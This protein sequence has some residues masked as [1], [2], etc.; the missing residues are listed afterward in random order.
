M[1]VNGLCH[2]RVTSD[3]FLFLKFCYCWFLAVC[4]QPSMV[5]SRALRKLVQLFKLLNA[6]WF[7]GSSESHKSLTVSTTEYCKT[8]IMSYWH[9]PYILNTANIV[10]WSAPLLHEQGSCRCSIDTSTLKSQDY[11]KL[12]S[13]FFWII[14]W[15]AVRWHTCKAKKPQ[16]KPKQKTPTV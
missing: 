15:S 7:F 11:S 16:T 10:V 13:W 8:N 1:W 5:M 14:N 12:P 4:F 9:I 3:L 6:S 2:N